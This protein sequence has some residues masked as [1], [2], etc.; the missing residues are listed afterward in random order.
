MIVFYLGHFCFFD[1]PDHS[2]KDNIPSK[3]IG[4]P[5]KQK[6]CQWKNPN[7][8][9]ERPST[10][11]IKYGTDPIAPTCM[12]GGLCIEK[13]LLFPKSL[14]RAAHSIASMRKLDIAAGYFEPFAKSQSFTA[15]GLLNLYHISKILIYYSLRKPTNVYFLWWI[16]LSTPFSIKI[17]IIVI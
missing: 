9:E 4:A 3:K 17:V 7:I 2:K 13:H 14:Q 15:S 1:Q 6:S 10:I 12:L 5:R 16:V 8:T 11:H